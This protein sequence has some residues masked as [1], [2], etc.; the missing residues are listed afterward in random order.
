M[1]QGSLDVMQAQGLCGICMFADVAA[2][3][4]E[5]R[6]GLVIP[7]AGSR[8][9]MI[10]AAIAAGLAPD[11]A[12]EAVNAMS[13]MKFWQAHNASPHLVALITEAL[14]G[15]IATF[16]GC[17]SGTFMKHGTGA[18]NPLADLLFTVAYLKVIEFLRRKLKARGLVTIADADGASAFFGWHTWADVAAAIDKIVDT[19][20][21]DD[22]AHVFD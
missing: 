14:T 7:I 16:E 15:S 12:T 19:S 21:A 2:A 8:E 20:Y 22:L 10:Q 11:F 6:K 9:E 5:V 18:G 13:D 4:A 3:F 1:V 17:G